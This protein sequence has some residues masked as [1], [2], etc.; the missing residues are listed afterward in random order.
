[1]KILGIDHVAI[2]LD[3]AAPARELFGQLLGIDDAGGEDVPG[4]QVLAHIFNTGGGKVE[5]LTPTASDSPIRKF[6]ARRGAGLH[7]IAFEVDDLQAW[8]G[9]LKER[10]IELID[11]HPR[12]GAEGN[13]IAFLHPRSTGG[14]LIE[15]CQ[16]P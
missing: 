12:Q 16:K 1:M 6:L 4:Q 3:E 15:L 13:L 8:L 5:L 9:H 10:G 2:A 14:V 11:D 7:H